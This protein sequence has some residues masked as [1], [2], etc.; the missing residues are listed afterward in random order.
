[1]LRSGQHAECRPDLDDLAEAHDGHPVGNR[2]DGCEIMADPDQ[3]CTEF[4]DEFLHFCENFSLDRDVQRG[5]RLVADNQLGA[6]KQCDRDRHA[7]AHAAGKLVREKVDLT[8]G[9]G[10]TNLRQCLYGPIS[11]LCRADVLMCFEREPDLRAD[12]KHRVQRHHRVLENHGNGLATDLPQLVRLKADQFAA[13][14]LDRALDDPAGFIDQADN[15]EAGDRLSR[16]GFPDKAENLTG[17]QREGDAVDCLDLAPCA[18][19]PGAK[20]GDFQKW[21]SGF[22]GHRRSLGLSWSRIWSPT[23]LSETMNRISAT[24]G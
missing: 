13:F 24:P 9:V 22:F 3:R 2:G 10:D 8:L 12:A 4:S 15:R 16:S 18:R 17:G 14:K 5:R 19:E 20:I 7:L 6:M 23:R 11:C 21:C 1:M